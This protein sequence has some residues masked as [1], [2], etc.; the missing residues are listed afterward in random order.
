MKIIFGVLEVRKRRFEKAIKHKRSNADAQA[1]FNNK[2]TR[3]L[4]LYSALKTDIQTGCGLNTSE[5]KSGLKCPVHCGLSRLQYVYFNQ[6]IMIFFNC[7]YE[8]WTSH[9]VSCDACW[10]PLRFL[11]NKPILLTTAA[12]LWKS[13]ALEDFKG[14]CDLLSRPFPC[15]PPPSWTKYHR[16]L[17]K[18][19]PALESV[20]VVADWTGS[21]KVPKF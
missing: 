14:I 15:S 16:M 12:I 8:R 5:V 1:D 9:L 4:H 19:G 7:R 13:K 21:C 17:I 20:S 11:L 18:G 6:I 2:T 3:L 10:F